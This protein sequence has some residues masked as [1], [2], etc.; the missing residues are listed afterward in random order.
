MLINLNEFQINTI[1]MFSV[2][3]VL[4][5]SL[6]NFFTKREIKMKNTLINLLLSILFIIS[7]A[8]LS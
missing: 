3:Y 2:I 5:I 6:F 4:I 1:I 8:K 7:L